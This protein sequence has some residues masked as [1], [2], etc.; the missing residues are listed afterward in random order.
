M[1]TA[2]MQVRARLARQ[3]RDN[4]LGGAKCLEYKKVYSKKLGE[5]VKRCKSYGAALAGTDI[6][7]GCDKC[8]GAEFGGTEF[9]GARPSKGLRKCIRTQQV[10]SAKLREPVT[11]CMEY[12][13]ASMY[14]DRGTLANRNNPWQNFVRDYAAMHPELASNR[15]ELLHMAS[16]AYRSRM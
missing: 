9:G 8:G 1:D 12:R 14:R 16:L 4:I 7:G 15:P 2:Q 3:I 11:R 5:K 10:Y 13:G 6:F